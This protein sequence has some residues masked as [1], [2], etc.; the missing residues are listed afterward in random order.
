MALANT[1]NAFFDRLNIGH[2]GSRF[3]LKQL[4]T[5]VSVPQCNAK[6]EELTQNENVEV[7]DDV[8]YI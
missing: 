7:G 1:R 5:E 6:A 4:K 2:N 8:V 3:A